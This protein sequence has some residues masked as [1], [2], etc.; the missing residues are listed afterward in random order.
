MAQLRAA[1]GPVWIAGQAA[2]TGTPLAEGAEVRTGPGAS[3]EVVFPDETSVRL[4]AETTGADLRTVP[5][6]RLE[7]ARGTLE[8]AVVPQPAGKPFTIS[9]PHAEATVVG[10]AL[11]LSVSA[12]ETRLEVT[13]GR[14]RLKRRSD[15]KSVDVIAGHVAMAAPGVPLA[16]HA[17]PAD[18]IVLLPRDGRAAG[19]EWT[20]VRDPAASSGFA[21]DAPRTTYQVRTLP[22]GGHE[23]EPL[24]ERPS[25]V[26]FSFF[27]EAAKDYHA[28]VRG[29]SLASKDRLKHD[30]VA[31]QPLGG[32]LGRPCPY[33]G[34]TGA[35][36]KGFS[37]Q[38]GYG[39]VGG[40][41][42]G[43]RDQAPFT[44]RFER[45]GLQTLRLYAV[46]APVRIDCIWLSA[47][48]KSR[49]RA[50]QGPP[51]TENR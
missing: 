47:A 17:F 28:W 3:A 19:A 32:R 50:E 44:I 24:A 13:E 34:E 27:A 16:A 21:L 11:R 38:E 36:Y 18:E 46:E 23:Y 10:T 45:T 51:R 30:E 37:L 9:T 14:V 40:N 31:L 12:A 35:A 1:A 42:E 41:A 22:G 29:R 8:A 20:A 26:A 39:W 4:G 2:T 7:L 5:A 48:Q 6:K 43:N 49:P 33:L 25:F 15:G